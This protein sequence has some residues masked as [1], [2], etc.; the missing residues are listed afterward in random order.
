MSVAIDILK[1]ALPMAAPISLGCRMQLA[2]GIA[3]AK[4]PTE[5][6]EAIS[7]GQ[8]FALHHDFYLPEPNR[9]DPDWVDQYRS[10]SVP[11]LIHA[12]R[13]RFS[14]ELREISRGDI[15]GGFEREELKASTI[16]EATSFGLLS[17]NAA[18]AFLAALEK[19]L[20]EEKSALPAVQRSINTYFTGAS[21][22][23]RAALDFGFLFS[24]FV[25]LKD[26]NYSLAAASVFVAVVEASAFALGARTKRLRSEANRRRA[27][28]SDK[29]KNMVEQIRMGR[30]RLESI[31]EEIPFRAES[32]GLVNGEMRLAKIWEQAGDRRGQAVVVSGVDSLSPLARQK[33]RYIVVELP[34]GADREIRV[35]TLEILHPHLFI[36]GE[37][38]VGAGMLLYRGDGADRL[39]NIDGQ[40]ETYP[41][42]E[43]SV[44]STI[45][46]MLAKNRGTDAVVR[47]FK[48]VMGDSAGVVRVKDIEELDS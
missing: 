8:R 20:V 41:T 33:L 7:T 43:T 24:S 21:V 9:N 16:V 10:V 39:I 38:L 28:K 47:T 2:M 27:L 35:A 26:W 31:K 3:A 19:R 48:E 34:D 5:I 22:M 6:L 30:T 32:P 45:P 13:P 17:Y 44:M 46:S 12:T 36:P 1:P 42:R 11:F 40:S 14:E 37:K 29:L 4:E 15:V 23:K 25:Y 18:V